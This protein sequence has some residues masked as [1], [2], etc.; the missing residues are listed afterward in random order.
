MGNFFFFCSKGLSAST[1]LS[2]KQ[3]CTVPFKKTRF[4][5]IYEVKWGS[6]RVKYSTLKVLSP[7]RDNSDTS[8]ESL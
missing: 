5:A 8:K 2:Q 3:S 6:L 7:K 1:K 4:L